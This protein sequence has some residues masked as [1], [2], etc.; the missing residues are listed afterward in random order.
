MRLTLRIRTSAKAVAI[1]TEHLAPGTP[2]S[3]YK[4]IRDG[5]HVLLSPLSSVGASTCTAEKHM[6]VVHSLHDP[7]NGGARDPLT[8]ASPLLESRRQVL[9]RAASTLSL[10]GRAIV[11]GKQLLELTAKQLIR[12]VDL[13]LDRQTQKQI[14][15]FC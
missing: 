7:P 13:P 4:L 12:T 8:R 6:D 15:G 10:D 3:F 1:K 9:N 14:L 2:E 11:D 5:H